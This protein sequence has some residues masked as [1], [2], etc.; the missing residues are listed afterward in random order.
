MSNRGSVRS[1]SESHRA[2][3]TRPDQRIFIPQTG[4]LPSALRFSGGFPNHEAASS[5]RHC[6][7]PMGLRL[8]PFSWRRFPVNALVPT[9]GKAVPNGPADAPNFSAVFPISPKIFPKSPATFPNFTPA[10]LIYNG[11]FPSHLGSIASKMRKKRKEKPSP[12]LSDT[13][14]HPMGEGRGEGL[15]SQP[16]T[17]N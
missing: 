1:F 2:K 9:G 17:H 13:L 15:Y 8:S 10:D 12:V 5:K 16:S 7:S 11:L 6:P 14:S 3:A 4:Q